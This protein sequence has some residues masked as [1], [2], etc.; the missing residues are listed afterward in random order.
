VGVP[1]RPAPGVG[2][3]AGFIA[4]QVTPAWSDPP[5][6]RGGPENSPDAA[7]PGGGPPAFGGRCRLRSEGDRATPDLR[8]RGSLGADRAGPAA[9]RSAGGDLGAGAARASSRA[10]PGIEQRREQ[11]PV[12][13]VLAG[14]ENRLRFSC[15]EDRGPPPRR[16]ELDRPMAL[17]RACGGGLQERDSGAVARAVNGRHGPYTDACSWGRSFEPH[18]VR[19]PSRVPSRC[20]PHDPQARDGYLAEGPSAIPSL[21]VGPFSYVEG[22]RAST[23]RGIGGPSTASGG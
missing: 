19:G 11:Q 17:R 13:Q 6:G 5:P 14:I 16:L 20:D 7:L 4:G 18:P 3:I 15:R 22:R 23:G 8:K 21:P 12:P 1:G 2:V 10:A 9:C